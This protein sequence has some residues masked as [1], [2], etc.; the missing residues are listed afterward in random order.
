MSVEIRPIL[1]QVAERGSMLAT[2]QRNAS[3]TRQD[4][5]YLEVH[6][7]D[8]VEPF[9]HSGLAISGGEACERHFGQHGSG[10]GIHLP[11]QVSYGDTFVCRAH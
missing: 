4:K 10:L 6:F 9:V 7:R 5:T 2:S 3:K 1:L 11:L 8:I